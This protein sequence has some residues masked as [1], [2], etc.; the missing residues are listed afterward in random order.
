MQKLDD[1]IGASEHIQY[2]RREIEYV[3]RK[4]KKLDM[5]VLITGPSGSGKEKIAEGISKISGI[6][7]FVVINCAAIPDSLFESELFGYVPGAFTGAL[8]KGKSGLVE[9]AEGGIL[10]LDEIGDLALMN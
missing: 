3:G 7:P 10:F 6:V 8:A 9:K 2:L 4:I 5:N 1:L